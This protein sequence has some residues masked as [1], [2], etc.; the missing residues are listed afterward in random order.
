MVQVV[1]SSVKGEVM[2]CFTASQ[3]ADGDGDGD[4]GGG[5]VCVGV[6]FLV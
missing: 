2:V 4:G 1:E 5:R 6:C 3:V